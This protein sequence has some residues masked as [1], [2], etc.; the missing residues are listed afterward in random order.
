MPHAE[1]LADQDLAELL[2]LADQAEA[3]VVLGKDVSIETGVV[4]NRLACYAVDRLIAF[5]LISE[6]CDSRSGYCAPG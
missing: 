1:R 4:V 6:Q 2:T 3:A 5:R